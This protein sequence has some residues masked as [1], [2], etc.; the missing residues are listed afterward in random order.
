MKDLEYI[1]KITNALEGYMYDKQFLIMLQ[2]DD[3][4]NVF[5]EDELLILFKMDALLHRAINKLKLHCALEKFTEKITLAFKT[6]S[7]N[8]EKIIKMI[9]SGDVKTINNLIGG[10]STKRRKTKKLLKKSRRHKKTKKQR[11]GM[12][13]ATVVLTED[14]ACSICLGDYNSA[15]EKYYYHISG[16][17][18]FHRVCI[19]PWI[20]AG[21]SCPI[22]RQRRDY[23]LPPPVLPPPVLPPPVLPPPVLPPP[24]LPPPVLRVNPILRTASIVGGVLFVGGIAFNSISLILPLSERTGVAI[25]IAVVCAFAINE[26]R[27]HGV[28]RRVI[29]SINDEEAEQA[30]RNF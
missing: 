28:R 16:Y 10:R 3:I 4:N 13:N 2:K 7:M 11:G 12:I 29:Q 20:T 17:H 25:G 1:K 30:A 24:V 18:R 21:N 9:Q 8:Q 6:G 19:A 14:T 23:V 5:S 15:E 27:N 22:C 26:L